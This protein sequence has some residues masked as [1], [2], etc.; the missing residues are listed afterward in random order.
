MTPDKQKALF[1]LLDAIREERITDE[2][3]AYLRQLMHHN[4]EAE[5]LYVEYMVFNLKVSGT[6]G[7][8]VRKLLSRNK[9]RAEQ[10]AIK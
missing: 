7:T 8:V 4:A 3:F 2:Q 9:L 6:N 5:E 1:E 10:T